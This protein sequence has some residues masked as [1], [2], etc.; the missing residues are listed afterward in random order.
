MRN[1]M[2]VLAL[3]LPLPAAD[4]PDAALLPEGTVLHVTVP[5]V[6]DLAKK[7]RALPPAAILKDEEVVAFLKS[8]G[9]RFQKELG[10]QGGAELSDRLLA[11]PELYP[12]RATF[13]VLPPR[14][15]NARVVL[16]LRAA[17]EADAR[18]SELPPF[19]SLGGRRTVEE[20][21]G[22]RVV[23]LRDHRNR[24]AFA[25]LGTTAVLA[26]DRALLEPFLTGKAPEKPLAASPRYVAAR[27][28]CA[29]EFQVFV[30]LESALDSEPSARRDLAP[31]LGTT[32][33][34]SLA[35]GL[36]LEA[37][38]ARDRM[39]FRWGGDGSGILRSLSDRPFARETASLAPPDALVF[40]GGNVDM[41]KLVG[42]LLDAATREGGA[43]LDRWKRELEEKLGKE[44]LRELSGHLGTEALFFATLPEGG[45]GG[46][47][48]DMA[49]LLE[50]RDAQKLQTAIRE[51]VRSFSGAELAEVPFKGRRIFHLPIPGGSRI[52]QIGF[53]YTF[54][55]RHVAFGMTP[56]ALKRLINRAEAGK[57]GLAE[58]TAFQEALGKLPQGASGILYV[59]TK[60]TVEYIHGLVVPVL[61]MFGARDLPF[62]PALFPTAEAF[63]GPF[64]FTVGGFRPAQGRIESDFYS[65]GLSPLMGLLGGAAGGLTMGA[66]ELARPDPWAQQLRHVHAASEAYRKAQGKP[67]EKMEDL[68]PHAPPEAWT[69]LWTSADNA[70][71]RP[72]LDFYAERKLAHP[73]KPA[74]DAI[75]FH[76]QQRHFEGGRLVV[77]GDGSVLWLTE[78][79]FAA[80][81]KQL[82]EGGK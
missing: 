70:G 18:L 8:L 25:E 78:E 59:N 65:E 9:P 57:G 72:I 75:L 36:R 44:S 17:K 19:R 34:Q 55:E 82:E 42:T 15:G 24:F 12:G 60:R 2:L 30:D 48:P 39:A 6:A 51:L 73:E 20:V 38:A 27:E 67:H 32:R 76:T 74:P 35:G 14:E 41:P 71:N 4:D 52:M 66:V 28:T 10:G 3:A 47:I 69:W 11:F 29:G 21:K 53:A 26:T 37:A 61:Q 81:A 23:E 31:I 33:L 79:E 68:V 80:R 45:V 49:V 63:S 40:A 77:L 62:D 58:E 5:S 43:D 64:R 46:L 7:L 1:L 13:A 50:V 22:G 16:V 54:L 56:L